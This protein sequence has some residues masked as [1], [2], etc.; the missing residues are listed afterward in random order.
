MWKDQTEGDVVN[1]NQTC[2]S[3]SQLRSGSFQ[4]SIVFLKLHNKTNV[5]TLKIFAHRE[6]ERERGGGTEKETKISKNTS[7]GFISTFT[8][9]T[10]LETQ[11]KKHLY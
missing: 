2:I 1:S 5:S 4:F 10:K 3:L 6:R 9:G 7:G 8:C 11:F